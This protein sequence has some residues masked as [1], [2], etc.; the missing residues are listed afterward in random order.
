MPPRSSNYR[1]R[2][3]VDVSSSM[4]LGTSAENAEKRKHIVFVRRGVGFPNAMATADRIRRIGG[5]LAAEN[6]RVTLLTV[7]SS[8]PPH[9][10]VNTEA[11]GNFEGID[12][13]YTS[14]T[15][16]RADS[17]IRRRL[18]D[19][20]AHMVAVWRILTLDKRHEHPSIF[21]GYD[22]D[23]PRLL[24]YLAWGAAELRGIPVYIEVN[25]RAWSMMDDKRWY[26]FVSPLFGT[27]GAV[28]IS[29]LLAKWAREATEG[30]PS[31]KV[32]QIPILA[33]GAEF[34]DLS[35]G[36]PKPYVVFSGSIA[37]AST[38]R[39][40]VEA[41]EKV[42]QA[43]PDHK[44]VLTGYK[45][46]DADWRALVDWIA[47]RG[48]LEQVNLLSYL[49]RNDLLKLYGEAKAL[50]IPLFSDVQSAA[51]FPTKIGEYLYSSRPVVITSASEVDRYFRDGESAYIAEGDTV[52][53][54][55]D[56][57]IRAL[58]DERASV[59]G[60]NGRRVAEKNFE[61]SLYRRELINFF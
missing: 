30:R 47:G 8:E 7:G 19:I 2:A 10:V 43:L 48:R 24:N 54:Y 52:D 37:Y 46:T 27:D 44:L 12:Y 20:R 9:R 13:E 33:S 3:D 57:L 60:R 1:D 41:M 32:L 42:W 53:A 11:R 28:V 61:V 56:A 39:F 17:F 49:P 59:V 6:A 16:I 31:Y 40:I 4:E 5:A 38:M 18:I 26:S 21:L 45:E 35:L 58:T 51:R 34:Q 36:P 25:E 14:G 50:L 23:G 55:G 15:T 22:M 29:E